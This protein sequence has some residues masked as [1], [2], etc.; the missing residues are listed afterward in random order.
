[1]DKVKVKDDEMFRAF[2]THVVRS[3]EHALGAIRLVES[4]G[5]FLLVYC[6]SLQCWILEPDEFVASGFRPGR[7]ELEKGFG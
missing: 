4:G 5:I 1:V 2:Y 7:F 6:D 3:K